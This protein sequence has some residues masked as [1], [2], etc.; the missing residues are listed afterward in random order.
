MVSW[1]CVAT[2]I[3]QYGAGRGRRPEI[4]DLTC[5]APRRRRFRPCR[6]WLRGRHCRILLLACVLCLWSGSPAQAQAEP[7]SG[8]NLWTDTLDHPHILPV[9]ELVEQLMA[10]MTAADKVGQLFAVP[11]EGSMLDR[12][13]DIVQLIHDYRIGGVV[14]SAQNQNVDNRPELNT[15]RQVAILTNQLQALPYGLYMPPAL[16][17]DA[18]RARQLSTWSDVEILPAPRLDT[19]LGI[20]LL[21][22][23][24]QTETGQ[25]GP[26][27][28]QGFSPVPNQLA[29][30][31]AWDPAFSQAMGTILGQELQAVGINALLGPSLDILDQPR[32]PQTGM[33]ATATFGGDSWWVGQHGLSFVRGIHEGSNQG[34]LTFAQHFPG[35][36]GSDRQLDEE[37]ATI[38]GTLEDLRRHEL[39][40]FARV[41]AYSPDAAQ[42]DTGHTDGL[43]ASHIRYSGFL[44]ARER[45]PPIS[46]SVH[47]GEMLALDEFR[48]WHADGGLIMSDELGVRAIRTYYDPS[49]QTFLANRIAHDAFLAGNDL[50]WLSQFGDAREE[51]LDV[52]RETVLFFNDQYRE[53]ADFALAVDET[54][55]RILA[56]KLRLYPVSGL[57]AHLQEEGVDRNHPLLQQLPRRFIPLDPTADAAWTHIG[58]H[59]LHVWGTEQQL[60]V[61]AAAP[62]QLKTAIVARVAQA[63]I[64]LLHGSQGPAT[65]LLPMDPSVN[66]RL[67][68][69]TDSRSRPVCA[70]C[71]PDPVL[72]TD[73]LEQTILRLFGP[74]ATR[75]IVSDQITSYSFAQLT[76]VLNQTA[77]NALQ[78]RLERDLADAD[79]ILFAMLDVDLKQ[80]PA[81]DAV[82]QFLRQRSNLA[83]EKRLAV[84][85]FDA[86][87][88]L[89]AT[90]ISKLA[91]FIAAYSPASPFV[92]S[93]VRALFR[94]LA[95]KGAPPISVPGTRFSNLIGRLEPDPGQIIPLT[96]FDERRRSRSLD[97]FEVHL[98]DTVAIQ[99][100]PIVDHNGHHVPDGTPVQ[101]LL[102]YPESGLNRY[103]DPVPTVD[104][105]AH[106]D[107]VLDRSETLKIGV[108]SIDSR[109]S[110]E[111]QIRVEA[112][113]AAEITSVQPV[114]TSVTGSEVP[115]PDTVPE[116][117][118]PD[119]LAGQLHIGS[120]LGAFAA[121]AVLLGTYGLLTWRR[122]GQSVL[123]QHLLWA[124]VAGTGAYIL[125]GTHWISVTQTIAPS[126]Y[127]FLAIPVA[128]VAALIPLLWLHLT[129]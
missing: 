57:D 14:L 39:L 42:R 63:A 102:T 31:A 64:T 75:Q 11:F 123:L 29:M 87:D 9:D 126:V 107:V 82:R 94:D 43:V 41:T 113:S 28:R 71:A 8:P 76:S 67:V 36:G 40:P 15:P 81:S 104:G 117:T 61:F 17:Q 74:D 46:L 121:M 60:S 118:G 58:I 72:D 101:F 73:M 25:F 34:V 47:L 120:F 37:L 106:I 30:G 55:R 62:M 92:S 53:K 48:S 54:V 103:A 32:R 112:E 83:L 22:V 52:L 44:R 49:E 26:S 3:W 69:F 1:K 19:A 65:G 105:L 100:G 5:I 122:F 66:D 23:V 38:Q 18:T 80:Y 119:P 51:R 89:D 125:Y 70:D 10:R 95:L 20:P 85:A 50:L 124:V 128:A 59:P 115:P 4:M 111:L 77:D 16:P 78:N 6:A 88:M 116:L 79:W 109:T 93:A 2:Q 33:R 110:V 114:I 99:A 86:P 24:A 21:V 98:G 97:Q 108:R 68:I 27:L 90:D 91:A 13:D 35:Q 56:A 96:L 129:E 84:L 12:T 7:E 45:T 127:P